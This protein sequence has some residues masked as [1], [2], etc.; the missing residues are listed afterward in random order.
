MI[1]KEISHRSLSNNTVLYEER[2]TREQLKKQFE[3]IR[4]AGEPSFGNLAEM[5]R[6]QR[7]TGR[8]GET[9][10]YLRQRTVNLSER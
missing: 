4:Y 2:P 7:R 1:Q 8:T 5:K 6:R 3:L 10:K 9:V